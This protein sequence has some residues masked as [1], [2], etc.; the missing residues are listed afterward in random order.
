MDEGRMMKDL[1]KIYNL[2]ITIKWRDF[3]IYDI[4]ITLKIG[5]AKVNLAVAFMYDPRQN[6]ETNLQNVIQKIDNTILE[7]FKK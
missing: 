1:E 5:E 6:Y 3:R 2:L 4:Y 7:F